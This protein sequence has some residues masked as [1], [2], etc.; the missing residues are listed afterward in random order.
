MAVGLFASGEFVVEVAGSGGVDVLLHP[1]TDRRRPA[2]KIR[3]RE[4]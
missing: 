2:R 4:E 3:Q 1:Q